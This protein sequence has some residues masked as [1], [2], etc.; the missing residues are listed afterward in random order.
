MYLYFF[1]ILLQVCLIFF[2]SLFLKELEQQFEKEKLHLED[3]KNQLRQ[4]LENLREELTTK[5]TSANQE[6]RVNLIVLATI[7][8]LEIAFNQ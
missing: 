4:Q 2:S 3:D 1:I 5:L 6:A 8:V 7:S